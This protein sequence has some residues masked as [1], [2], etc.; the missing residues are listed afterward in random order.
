MEVRSVMALIEI[1]GVGRI[2]VSDA[3]K[4]MPPDQQG[5]FIDSILSEIKGGK[6]SSMSAPMPQ[7]VGRDNWTGELASRQSAI[8]EG[9]KNS[10]PF[11]PQDIAAARLGS[12]QREGALFGQQNKTTQG[13]QSAAISVNTALDTVFLGLPTMTRAAMAGGEVPFPERH[14]FMKS[15]NAAQAE[16]N[17]I[18]SGIGTGAGILGQIATIPVSGAASVMGRVGTGAA[19]AGLLSGAEA[20]I[21][22]RG[23][24][25]KGAQA[26]AMG[27]L[28]GGGLALKARSKQVGWRSIRLWAWRVLRMIRHRRQRRAWRWRHRRKN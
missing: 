12:A 8:E 1:E 27:G 9:V 20:L 25:R 21:D 18:A 11:R 16:Q 14:E 23:D 7:A 22:S 19:Q 4:T 15:A 2:E 17:P 3:F 26:G 6:K 24:L 10:G 13:K 5:A 28:L